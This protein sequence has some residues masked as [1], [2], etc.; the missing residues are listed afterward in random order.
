[1]KEQAPHLAA[2]VRRLAQTAWPQ[3]AISFVFLVAIGLRF[4]LW[5]VVLSAAVIGAAH[6]YLAT[7]VDPGTAA[8]Q[9]D[10]L[11]AVVIGSGLAS[12]ALTLK[13]WVLES[14]SKLSPGTLLHLAGHTG[15][16]SSAGL[17]WFSVSMQW[18]SCALYSLIVVVW[19]LRHGRAG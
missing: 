18:A 11:G 13:W 7:A 3:L 12:I 6:A 19:A 15:R 14:Q 16:S 9:D 1:M 4:P 2:V 8:P 5:F 17:T 10:L